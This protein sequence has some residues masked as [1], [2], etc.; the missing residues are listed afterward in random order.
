[1]GPNESDDDCVVKKICCQCG[2]DIDIPA[3]VYRQSQEDLLNMVKR[4]TMPADVLGQDNWACEDCNAGMSR[5]T[6]D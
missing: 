6:S 2:C 1:M 5:T 3:K 4:G